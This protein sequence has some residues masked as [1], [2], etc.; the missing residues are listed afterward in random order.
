MDASP[1]QVLAQRSRGVLQL[2][3]GDLTAARLTLE[4]ALN[5]A[6]TMPETLELAPT[7]LAMSR[8]QSALGDCAS[9]L[10]LAHQSLARA[11]VRQHVIEANL[12]LAN[13]YVDIGDAALAHK[14]ADAAISHAHGLDSPWM[15][16][17]ALTCQARAFGVKAADEAQRLFEQA[18]S[19]AERAR[20][21]YTR[22]LA[23]HSYAQFLRELD[24]PGPTLTSPEAEAEAERIIA[25]LRSRIGA[26]PGK[27]DE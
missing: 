19:A 4:D 13:L 27:S 1:I 20:A 8:L 21:P 9:A 17:G 22:A 7:L 5:L 16:S 14:Y 25:D 10:D 3:A 11:S 26:R 23:L 24:R 6:Q 12:T 15:L 18:I 2:M